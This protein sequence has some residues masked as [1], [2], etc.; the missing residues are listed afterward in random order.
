MLSYLISPINLSVPLLGIENS[1]IVTNEYYKKY[2]YA[3]SKESAGN[4]ETKK[5]GIVLKRN[6]D[7]GKVASIII[8]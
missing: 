7:S 3:K 6:V 8:S 5:K 4:E 1:L 2:Q